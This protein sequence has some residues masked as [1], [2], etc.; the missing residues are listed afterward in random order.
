MFLPRKFS[1][2]AYGPVVSRFNIVFKFNSMII[3]Y[4]ELPSKLMY[5]NTINTCQYIELVLRYSHQVSIL[6]KMIIWD[7]VTICNWH[8]PRNVTDNTRPMLT[9]PRHGDRWWEYSNWVLKYNNSF[10]SSTHHL[11]F[12]RRTPTTLCG[13]QNFH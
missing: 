8:G 1:S 2:G 6:T 7:L 4:H 11:F 13:E 3:I 9:E 12:Q 5:Y 10:P